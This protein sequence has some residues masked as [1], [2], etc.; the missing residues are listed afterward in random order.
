MWLEYEGR[1]KSPRGGRVKAGRVTMN[2]VHSQIM[3]RDLVPISDCTSLVKDR[4]WGNTHGH[5]SC[6]MLLSLVM[7]PWGLLV[8]CASGTVIK[9]TRSWQDSAFSQRQPSPSWQ[10]WSEQIE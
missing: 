4:N 10:E 7:Q 2:L 5:G 9:V 6:R 8:G 1:W 3:G